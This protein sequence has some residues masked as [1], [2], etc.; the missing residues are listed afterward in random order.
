M[1]SPGSWIPGHS[2]WAICPQ[3]QRT[4]WEAAE[5]HMWL[6]PAKQSWW[7]LWPQEA[8]DQW[9]WN[10]V[11]LSPLAVAWSLVA[12]AE[13]HKGLLHPNCRGSSDHKVTGNNWDGATHT[14]LPPYPPLSATMGGRVSSPGGPGCGWGVSH[15][16]APDGKASDCND[17]NNSK[18]SVTSRSAGGKNKS[19]SDTPNRGGKVWN[20]QILWQILSQRQLR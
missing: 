15:S 5:V 4:K 16:F 19:N 1:E 8:E 7:H 2:G 9:R 13:V 14:R 12:A 11:I 6:Q 10:S 18:A 3:P 20:V 17:T